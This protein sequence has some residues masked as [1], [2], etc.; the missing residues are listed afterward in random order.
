MRVQKDYEEFLKSLNRNGVKYCIVGAFALGFY[1]KP[2]FTKDIDIVVEASVENGVR[3]IKALKEFG[4]VTLDVD[5]DDFIS[6]G[7]VI[8]LGYEPV[9]IDIL[10]SLSG[11]KFDEVWSGKVKGRYGDQEVY[12]IGKGDLVKNK[13]S[14]GREQDKVDLMLLEDIEKSK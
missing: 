11:V 14:T 1:A 10:T 5:A 2:R 13:R 7:Q 9:R 4:F 8:Q 12:F 6:E 3:I